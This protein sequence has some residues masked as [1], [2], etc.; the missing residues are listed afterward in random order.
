MKKVDN[1]MFKIIAASGVLVIVVAL[2]VISTPEFSKNDDSDGFFDMPM[3]REE[4]AYD[5]G[6]MG[7][8]ATSSLGYAGE[9]MMLAD[10]FAPSPIMMYGGKTAAEAEQRIIK[11]ADLAIAV[12]GVAAKTQEVSTLATGRGGFVQ[13]S[14][15][16]EDESG[17]K[18]GYVVVRVPSDK[19]EATITDIKN[20]AVRIDRESMNGQDVTEQYTDLE[21]R[22]K[23]A[24]A[25]EEQYLLILDKAETVDEILSVQSYLQNI[26]YEIESLQGQID[27]I[28][29]QTEYSTISVSLSEEIRVKVPTEKFDLGRDIRLAFDAVVRLIQAGL[30]FTVFFVIVGGAIAIPVALLIALTVWVIKKI[31]AR[32]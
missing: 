3:L 9:G 14:T 6:M 4:S 18:T 19:F 22:L 32:L 5:S 1:K 16:V 27:S 29:N 21:A 17:Y 24:K 20:L 11:T 26:R 13:S 30:S 15:L 12:D 31:V 7:A 28:G 10:S 23:S 8:V 2:A 25:Q